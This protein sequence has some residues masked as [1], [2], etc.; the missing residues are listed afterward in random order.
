MARRKS[1]ANQL[2]LDGQRHAKATQA[3]P[4]PHARRGGRSGVPRLLDE[5]H[6]A[7][8]PSPTSETASSRC[9]VASCGRCTTAI[10]ARTGRS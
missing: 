2:T 1:P 10:R 3:D 6:R 4:D 9:T 5:R 7:H 8:V